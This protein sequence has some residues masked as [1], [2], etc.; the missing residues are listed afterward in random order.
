MMIKK[1]KSIEIGFLDKSRYDR[2]LWEWLGVPPDIRVEQSEADILAGR[3]KQL[4]YA[5][6]MLK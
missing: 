4:E 5:I 6:E 3:D 2:L 1:G